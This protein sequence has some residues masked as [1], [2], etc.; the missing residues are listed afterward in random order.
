MP[1]T[2]EEITPIDEVRLRHFL[3]IV[4]SARG[5]Y[6]LNRPPYGDIPERLERLANMAAAQGLIILHADMRGTIRAFSPERW[7]EAS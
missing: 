6:C 5:G 4:R 3:M 7:E 1:S 2:L